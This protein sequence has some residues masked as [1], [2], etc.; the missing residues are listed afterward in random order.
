MVKRF[1]ILVLVVILASCNSQNYKFENQMF[2][3][4]ASS[5]AIAGI[6]LKKELYLFENH[7]I[8]NG[9]LK[10]NSGNS[11]YDIYKQIEFYNDVKCKFNYSFLDTIQS[12][13]SDLD[14]INVMHLD[15]F[16]MN[17][18]YKKSKQYLLDNALES[19]A[20]NN[21]LN[22][23]TIAKTITNILSPKDFEQDYYKMTLLLLLANVQQNKDSDSLRKLPPIDENKEPKYIHQR[24]VVRIELTEDTNFVCFN[25]DKS[26]VSIDDLPA[27]LKE[28]ILNEK[29]D[30]S[31]PELK[32][33]NI[34]NIGE[35]Y[36]SNYLILLI[37]PREAYFKTFN[38]VQNQVF[39]AIELAR[40]EMSVKYFKKEYAELDDTSKKAIEKLVPLKIK[41]ES[42]E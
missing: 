41:H 35:C 26:K 11:Y 12:Q 25:F 7:L 22:P 19:L 23:S 42:I 3:C 33:V 32:P 15:C 16:D 39:K 2:E 38:A 5:L 18:A 10:D 1:L 17:T 28:F 27:I 30:K 6:D 21:I 40:N 29:D 24:D 37:A 13:L 34:E 4:L 14:T 31:K 9:I 8:E 20:E 36:Q